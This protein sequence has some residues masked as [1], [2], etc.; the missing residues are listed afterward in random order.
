MTFPL[1]SLPMVLY[2]VN[3]EIHP[4]IEKKY[5]LW[6]RKHMADIVHEAGFLQAILLKNPD[7]ESQWKAY[8]SQYWARDKRTVDRYLKEFAPRF[9]QDG[10]ERWKSDF[11]ATR[12]VL[13]F[14]QAVPDLTETPS[15]LQ[16]VISQR[17]G[18]FMNPKINWQKLITE[19]QKYRDIE[20]LKG[21]VQRI[22]KDVK[23]FDFHTVLTPSAQAKVK[24]FEKQYGQLLKKVQVAQR[25]ADREFNRLLRQVK[26]YRDTLLNRRN[27]QD[28]TP[29]KKKTTRRKT[30][31]AT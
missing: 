6:L 25:Q 31:K 16:F 9:R 26:T 17:K 18:L 27:Q 14:Q 30:K 2:E 13:H 8:C 19:V 24:A 23:N 28:E 22:T 15:T 7:S 5:L 3:L 10:I 11:K 12:R 4:R 21:E 29:K 20:K 1:V